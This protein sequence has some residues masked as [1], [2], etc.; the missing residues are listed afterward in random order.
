[1]ITLEQ[2]RSLRALAE[3][4][5]MSAAA[6][7][8][9]LSQPTLSHHIGSLESLLGG[10]VA[11]RTRRGSKLTRLGEQAL[12]HA[13]EIL[14]RSAA[15]EQELRA[16]AALDATTA[17]VGSFPSAA[18]SLIAP[19]LARA[20]DAPTSLIVAE[21]PELLELLRKRALHVAVLAYD[22]EVMPKPIEGVAIEPLLDDPYVV[23][24]PRGHP[25][26]LQTELALVDL[27]SDGWI[28]ASTAVDPSRDALFREFAKAGREPQIVH[29][30]DDYA[31]TEALVAAGFGVALIPSI[32]KGRR[33]ESSAV[34]PS[35][36]TQLARRLYVAHQTKPHNAT[37]ERIVSEIRYIGAN[38]SAGE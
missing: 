21:Q 30:I 33:G 3:T 25:A 6:A 28:V 5:T 4:G 34:R 27:M 20:A 2:W 7:A 38:L 12:L 18:A 24:L 8:I 9:Y 1:M 29:R 10:P 19:A 15:A 22:T 14:N 35:S 17:T 23:L 32:I 31:V 11:V 36:K 13:E 26:S 37:V 16:E